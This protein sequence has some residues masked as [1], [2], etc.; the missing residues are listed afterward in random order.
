MISLVKR[1]IVAGDVDGLR[2]ALRRHPKKVHAPIRWGFPPCKTEPLHFLSDGFFH[3]L[4][5]HSREENL[6]ETF[7]SAGAPVNGLPDAG[8]TPLHGAASLGCLPVATALVQ[9]DADLERTVNYPGIQRGTTLDFA[10]HFGMTGI[11]DLLA[12]HG[13][14]MASTP[15]MAGAEHL[16][17][18][19]RHVETDKPDEAQCY[20]AFRCASVCNRI[21]I[22]DFLLSQGL[23][24]DREVNG[25]T[26]LHWAAW[27]GKAEMV[28]HLTSKGASRDSV[29]P[30]FG[31]T[32]EGWAR[33]RQKEIGAGWGHDRVIENLRS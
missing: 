33:H 3:R 7:L 22:V 1:L 26:A 17:K 21:E 30:R 27:E 29:D 16:D 18:F 5:H 31:L 32:P 15:T 28:S 9:N 11:V 6:A 19:Q 20:D 12:R 13:A 25:G 10:V 4:W 24:I 8:E 23:D 2:D 14:S